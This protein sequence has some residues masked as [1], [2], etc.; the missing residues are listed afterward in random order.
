MHRLVLMLAD[1]VDHDCYAESSLSLP[2]SMVHVEWCQV[3]LSPCQVLI[4]ALGFR[5]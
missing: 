5:V 2:G 1:A 4:E 3:G